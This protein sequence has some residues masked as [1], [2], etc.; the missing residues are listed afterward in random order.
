[1]STFKNLEEIKKTWKNLEKMS[2]NPVIEKKNQ[3]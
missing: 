2:G 1:M 3:K